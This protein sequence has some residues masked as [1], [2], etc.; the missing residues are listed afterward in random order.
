M[1]IRGF[2]L[3]LG[4]LLLAFPAVAA[5]VSTE[6]WQV[7]WASS[8][9]VLVFSYDDNELVGK[10]SV[11]KPCGK[12]LRKVRSFAYSNGKRRHV[13]IF[14]GKRANGTLI[15]AFDRHGKN[16]MIGVIG[17]GDSASMFLSATTS[18][19]VNFGSSDNS[20]S[21]LEACV[22]YAN[23]RA[24]AVAQDAK[25]PKIASFK[26]I[27]MRSLSEQS[28]FPFSGGNGFAKDEKLARG[29]CREVKKCERAFNSKE[30]WCEVVLEDGFFTGWVKRQDD[31]WVYLRQGC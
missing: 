18:S 20:G 11:K 2:I 30:D 17:D 14:S 7:Q 13:E 16:K 25:N 19:S 15:G 22:R 28:I 24:C 6:T 4:G 31:D 27:R 1:R 8:G 21:N 29:E 26:T 10:V 12:A 9:C 5:K 23:N 3:F